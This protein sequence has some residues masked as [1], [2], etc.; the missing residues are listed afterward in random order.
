MTLLA[1]DNRRLHD[2][3]TMLRLDPPALALLRALV[4]GGAAQHPV[5]GGPAG[6][7]ARRLLLDQAAIDSGGGL[8]P[9]T[10]ALLGPL[11]RPSRRLQAQVS[12][13]TGRHRT[14]WVGDHGATVATPLSDG[15]IVLRRADPT[16][17]GAE[18][19]SWL[20]IRPLPERSGRSSWTA[21]PLDP[22]VP[23]AQTTWIVERHAGNPASRCWVSAIDSGR[24]GWRTASGSGSHRP[25]TVT[26]EPVGV[27]TIYVALS[28]LV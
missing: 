6:Q 27:A 9:S 10:W 4:T 21:C 22:E 25:R 2:E 26:F 3:S 15:T 7:A 11:R 8:S 19:V 14:I 16:H 20:G 13:P 24:D 18:L 12:G 28:H 1:P 17:I 23:D 5:F